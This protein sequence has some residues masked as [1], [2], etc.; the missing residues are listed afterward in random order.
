MNMMDSMD[1]GMDGC[2]GGWDGG[3]DGGMNPMAMFEDM[4]MGAMMGMM[5]MMGAMDGKG[6]G[7]GGGKG[8]GKFKKA[9]GSVPGVTDQRWQGVVKTFNPR[10]FGF[11]TCDELF[12]IMGH[13]VFLHEAQVIE[14]GESS[15]SPGDAVTFAVFIN[16]KGQPQARDL[17]RASAFSLETC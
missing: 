14:L 9:G 17:E 2:G 3:F 1:G 16:G 13:D 5:N 8:K 4:D 11:I 6:D 10:G 15:L 7:K 12:E